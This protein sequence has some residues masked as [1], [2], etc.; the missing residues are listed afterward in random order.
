[1]GT[2]KNL[3]MILSVLIVI[4][5]SVLCQ[6]IIKIS[7][8]NQINK[9]EVAELNHIRYGLMSINTWK[10]QVEEIITAEVDKL[11][12]TPEHEIELKTNLEAQLNVLID[13]INARIQQSNKGSAGGWVKQAFINIFVSIDE[14]KKGIPGYADAM[15]KEMKRPQAQ[16]KIKDLLKDKLTSYI[17]QTF[18][19]QDMSQVERILA[20]TNSDTIEIARLKLKQEIET[21]YAV[22][23][24]QAIAMI[25]LSIILFLIP[26]FSKEPLAPFEYF[27]MVIALLIMIA[28]GV[29][30]P[31]IDMEAKISQMTFVL[32]NHPI[33]FENQ[34]LFF[35]TKSI[36]DVFWIMITDNAIQMKFV[37]ILMICF[38]IIFPLIK[39]LS[40]VAYYYNYRGLR[41]NRTIEFF[42]LKSGKWSMADVLVVAI[43]MAY[44]GFNGIIT[45]QFGK[46]ATASKEIV[47]LTTNGTNLQPGYFIFLTYA[48]LAMVLSGYLTRGPHGIKT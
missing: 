40:S 19:K 27:S 34:V 36:I 29:T 47:I 20:R 42:V 30:T 12:I 6:Q 1:M 33:Q 10:E 4:S 31:M 5:L 24:K 15:I 44:I 35:Q 45:S 23:E 11:K 8:A 43:F 25:I 22:V 39:L 38:S 48:L 21:N 16:G 13:K 9:V 32:M 2:M 26:A 18:D 37:G 28:A 7:N 17:D 3:K 41:H 46:L 14:V